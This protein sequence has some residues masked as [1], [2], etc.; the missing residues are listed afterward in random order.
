MDMKHIYI[1][2][3]I[4][5]IYIPQLIL[6]LIGGF[7][8]SE[9]YQSIGIIILNIWENKKCSQPE[10]I[11][12]IEWEWTDVFIGFG[13]RFWKGCAAMYPATIVTG[14][15]QKHHAPKRIIPNQSSTYP[16][17]KD[18]GS[19]G[20]AFVLSCSFRLS[21]KCDHETLVPEGR[22]ARGSLQI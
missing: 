6:I 12:I 14:S 10:L 20:A 21:K 7:N 13:T 17:T 16:N 22:I 8:P 3:I 11:T 19:F 4:I 5:Y 9:K 2:Y 1:Y 15:L 18:S